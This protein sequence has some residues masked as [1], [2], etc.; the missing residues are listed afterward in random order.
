[1]NEKLTQFL[2]DAF[3]PYGHF[4]AR[5]DVEQELLANLTE[6]YNDLKADGKND[7]EAYK[8]TI[9]SFGDVT[10]IMEQVA[11]EKP[12]RA[13]DDKQSLRK[14][15]VDSIMHPINGASTSRFRATS[16]ID[17]DLADTKLTGSDFSMSALMNANFDKS[18]LGASKFKATALK[19]A[20]FV[21][22]NLTGSLFDSSDLTEANLES[23]NLADAEFRRCAFKGASFN[24]AILDNTTFKQSD[25]GEIS[26][27][28][29]TLRGTVFDA[30]SLKKATF[31][32]ADLQDV[33]FHYSEVKHIIFDG[34]TM[35]KVTYAL[36]KG[37]KANLDNVTIK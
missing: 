14:T 28:N 13:V 26:F 29:L 30:S 17:T 7:D 3:R 23:A 32:G 19:G 1:M 9:E 25:L 24:N 11:H 36:L 4:P 20:S 37:V 12:K 21:G 27:D 22:A 33:S 6:K 34:A 8:L 35:D 2:D 16:L 15:I 18:E 10:E 31:K 5:K